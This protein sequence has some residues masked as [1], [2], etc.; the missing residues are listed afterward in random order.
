[1]NPEIA[2]TLAEADQALADADALLTV[3]ETVQYL[4][5]H[6]IAVHRNT[7]RH[8]IHTGRIQAQ[9]RPGGSF[10]IPRQLLEHMVACP[11]CRSR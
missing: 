11:Y 4:A 10:L 6:R 7:V 3:T 1:M 9:R 8:W 5:E 2:R